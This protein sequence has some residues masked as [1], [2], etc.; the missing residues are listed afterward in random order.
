VEQD[1]HFVSGT[2]Q[3]YGVE[4]QANV[5]SNILQGI[6]ARKVPWGINLLVILLMVL[7]GFLLRSRFGQKL[8]IAIGFESPTLNRM[9]KIPVG[10]LSVTI[11]Y[12]VVIYFVY[13]RSS[14]VVDMTPHIVT[15]FLAY[16]FYGL[17][18]RRKRK[19]EAPWSNY[20]QEPVEV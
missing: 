4:I 10:L 15:L 19:G 17:R 20:E 6:Y 11:L 14:Y 2:R 3:S 7:L 16:W 1:R 9:L 13:S 18:G 12:F 8:S 5:I